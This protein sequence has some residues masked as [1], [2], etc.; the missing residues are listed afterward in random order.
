MNAATLHLYKQ[1]RAHQM[2]IAN[3]GAG[4]LTT[5]L[6]S[7]KTELSYG[8]APYGKH[9][10]SAYKFAIREIHFRKELKATVAGHKKRA[11][12][13]RRGWKTRRAA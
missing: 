8:S 7:G 6:D 12:A 9:A 10:I 4:A 1:N 13:A 11:K 2:A 3:N 5:Y